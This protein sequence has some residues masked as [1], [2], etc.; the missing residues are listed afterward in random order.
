LNATK[1]ERYFAKPFI[2][3][4]GKG[5]IDGVYCIAKDWRVLASVASGSG[6]GGMS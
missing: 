4:L 2:G 6:D 3:Q 1:L 5:H